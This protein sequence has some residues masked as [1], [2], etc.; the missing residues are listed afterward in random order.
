ML[1]FDINIPNFE[2]KFSSYVPLTHHEFYQK[3]GKEHYRLLSYFSTFFNNSVIF[4][5]GT[6]EGKSA[7]ALSYNETNKVISFDILSKFKGNIESK[8]NVEFHIEN[9]FYKTNLDKWKEKLLS[10][11]LI[12]I[13]IAPHDGF[14]EYDMVMWLKEHDYK[15]IIIL[16]DIWYYRDMRINLWYKIEPEYRYDVTE[17]GHWAGTGLVIFNS[18]I[19]VK[20][21]NSDNW[22]LVTAYFN[23]TK[24]VDASDEIKKRDQ[25]Y[26][27]SHSI[28]TL[29]LDKNLVIYCDSES[30]QKIKD[31]RPSFLNHKT[32]YIVIEFEDIP[33]VKNRD[34]IIQNRIDKPYNFDP[35]NT[36]SYY[37]FCMSRYWML[38]DTIK[39][40]PFN[41]SHF[42]WINFCIERMGWKNLAKLD[43]ALSQ[44]KDKF[45]TTYIDFISES[46]V[47]NTHEYFKRGRCSMCSGFFT[48]NSEHM[49]KVC[50]LLIE[51][52][53]HYLEAGYGHSD[54][55]LYSPVFFENPELFDQHFGDYQSV[56]TN[57]AFAYD[58]IGSIVCN[59]I[60]NS[61]NNN[62]FDLCLKACEF[63][64]KSLEL[65]KCEFQDQNVKNYFEEV[66]K[67]IKLISV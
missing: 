65:G 60:R 28:A 23:L 18:E 15:G 57:Y 7:L 9:I 66:Y 61:Y 25:A 33:I 12:F 49:Y 62:R 30:Y 44:N 4:D 38:M 59:F 63:V 3:S 40:N 6:H 58:D 2:S 48:G 27:L 10:S 8:S 47:Q 56:I 35:R 19:K 37:L 13:D 54:E 20:T 46:L 50:E 14:L 5:I 45:S 26:Y 43:E 53:Y 55:Q 36:P 64:Q 52:F 32:R 51:K 41:S 39:S 24:C 16:D 21:N 17:F 31:L 29:N 34:K 42:C 67:I 1:N 22:T 11:P